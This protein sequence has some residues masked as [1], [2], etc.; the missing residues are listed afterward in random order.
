LQNWFTLQEHSTVVANVQ[1]THQGSAQVKQHVFQIF[2]MFL[3]SYL[4]QGK[5]LNE[6]SNT[7]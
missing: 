7:K 5:P 6:I 4:L 1:D 2:G 3:S